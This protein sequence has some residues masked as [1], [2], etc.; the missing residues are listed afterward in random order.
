MKEIGILRNVHSNSAVS[1]STE[2]T[3][4]AC[5]YCSSVWLLSQQESHLIVERSLRTDFR[6]PKKRSI[7]IGELRHVLSVAPLVPF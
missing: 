6:I 5:G 1:N 2:R 4:R 3:F 7:R